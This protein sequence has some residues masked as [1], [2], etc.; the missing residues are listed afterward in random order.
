MTLDTVDRAYN[1]ND[2][3]KVSGFARSFAGVNLND[4]KLTYRVVREVQYPFYYFSLWRPFPQGNSQEIVNGNTVAETDGTFNFE[5]QAIPDKTVDPKNKP[6][7][8]YKVVVD[9]TDISG[10]THSATTYIKVGYVAIELKADIPSQILASEDQEIEIQTLNLNGKPE[11]SDV[12]LKIYQLNQES[13]WRKN[14]LWN[15]PDQFLYSKEEHDRRTPYEL[16][17]NELDPLTWE[18]GA[19]IFE[20]KFNTGTET[21]IN[22]ADSLFDAGK[23]YLVLI[24]TKDKADNELKLEQTIVANDFV[25]TDYDIPAVL[26]WRFS[27]NEAESGDVLKYT[28]SSSENVHLKI[29]IAFKGELIEEEWIDLNGDQKVYSL[30]IK[31]EWQGGLEFQYTLMYKNRYFYEKKFIDVLYPD[32]QLKINWLSFRDKLLP[33]E[34]EEWIMEILLPD[35]EKAHAELLATMYDASLDAL[36]PHNFNFSVNRPKYNYHLGR[37]VNH[38]IMNT[39]GRVFAKNLN[40]YVGIKH[41]QYPSLNLFG[42]YMNN[43][44]WYAANGYLEEVVVS[45]QGTRNKKVFKRDGGKEEAEMMDNDMDG[46]FTPES[47]GLHNAV[48]NVG[49]LLFDESK[50]QSREDELEKVELRENFAETALFE[51]HLLTD[52][53]GQIKISFKIPESLTKWKIMTIGHDQNLNYKHFTDEFVTQKEIMIESFSPRF[54]RQGDKMR[55]VAKASNLTD[56]AINA[57]VSLKL[58]DAL[59]DNEVTNNLLKADRIQNVTV[60]AGQSV[61]VFWWIDIPDNLSTLTYEVKASAGKYTDGEKNTIPI[62]TNRSLV[63]ETLPLPIRAGQQKD[64]VFDH[65]AESDQSSTLTHHGIT[66][67]MTANPVWYVVQAL[68]YLMEYPYDCAEQI[69]SRFYGNALG[70]HIVSELPVIQKVFEQWENSEALISALEKNQE[71]KSIL[72]EESPWVRDAINETEQKKRIALLFDINNM[73]KNQG[74]TLEKLLNMQ[75]PNGGFPWFPGMRDNWYI[76]QY[77]VEGFGHLYKLGVIK[78]NQYPQLEKMLAHAVRYIDDRAN[79]AFTDIKKSDKKYHKNDHLSNILIH[80]LYT[81]TFYNEKVKLSQVSGLVDY[82]LEQADKFWMNKGMQEKA[83]LALAMHRISDSETPNKIMTYFDENAIISEE[84]GMYWKALESGGYYWYQAPVETQSLIIE[85]YAEVKQ[86]FKSVD[87]LKIWLLKQKQVQNWKSTKSTAEACYALLLQGSDWLNAKSDLTINMGQVSIS[88]E[89]DAIEPGTGYVK[90]SW[91]ANE[92]KA[93]MANIEI[94]NKGE[95]PAWGAIYWQYFEDIDKVKQA[96][97]NLKLTKE[98]FIEKPS[99]RGPV[100]TAI[101]ENGAEIGDLVKVR[102]TLQTDRTMEYVH[103]KDLR[104]SGLEPVN[105]LSQYKYKDGLGYYEMT[106]DAATHFFFDYLPKGEYVFEYG[107]RVAHAGEFSNGFTNIEC[108]YA[109]EFKSHSNG[110]SISIVE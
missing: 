80:Y 35:D 38:S 6:Y 44:G 109:P 66:L 64:F 33:G 83:L 39:S 60:D 102:I 58:I 1:I 9:V 41:R 75:L 56:N 63:A 10:E 14:R 43:W 70:R 13:T 106:K 110:S 107:L 92:V 26:N 59:T 101:D 88:T 25:N 22:L 49:L 96:E 45:A 36:Y 72:L 82:L 47:V 42:F 15:A 32:N 4:A 30:L 94:I 23:Q 50:E 17:E 34:E 21:K 108:M 19:P 99:D 78:E 76:T 5:F 65:L 98:L 18:K 81:R 24:E 61:S 91:S 95:V 27:Q 89:T 31:E 29:Q 3:V 7:F 68:P 97:T 103:M 57:T 51:P 87:E 54:M 20:Q 73:A 8:N 16:F 52:E 79:E 55:M 46:A 74:E 11:A 2:M 85:A 90:K 28:L 105:V 77:I 53:N 69:F 71:L 67:E 104:A 48:G 40:E 84:L 86:D 93:E 100:L 62:L 12:E 37:P